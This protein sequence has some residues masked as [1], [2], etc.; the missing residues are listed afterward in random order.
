MD[1]KLKA[2]KHKNQ[3]NQLYL[4]KKYAN[5]GIINF[6]RYM[7]ASTLQLTSKKIE[8]KWVILVICFLMKLC[9]FDHM[10][11]SFYACICAVP[12]AANV[13]MF[14]ELYDTS[15]SYA[16]HNVGLSSLL[17]IL[18]LPLVMYLA[19]KIASLPF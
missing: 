5:C 8:Y 7:E 6:Q 17:S 2:K 16:A 4:L 12:V 14:S 18:S 10:H 3:M 15:A 9:G 11:L 19:E 13:T 1:K